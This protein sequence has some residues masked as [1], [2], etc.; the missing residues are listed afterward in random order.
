MVYVVHALPMRMAGD[1]L[2]FVY[3]LTDSE[4]VKKVT[5]IVKQSMNDVKTSITPKQFELAKAQV[6]FNMQNTLQNMGSK[7]NEIIQQYRRFGFVIPHHVFKQVL[8]EITLEDIQLLARQMFDGETFFAE[9][10]HK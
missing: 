4:N 8:D 2:L 10:N 6:M 1:D 7:S 9:F 3:A 5:K